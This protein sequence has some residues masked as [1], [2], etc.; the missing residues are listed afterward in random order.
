MPDRLGLPPE[1]NQLIEKRE[2]KERRQPDEGPTA[3]QDVSQDSQGETL[4]RRSGKDRR[5]SEPDS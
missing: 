2:G 3:P 4:E 5:Q 1:L